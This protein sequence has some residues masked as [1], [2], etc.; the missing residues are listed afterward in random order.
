MQLGLASLFIYTVLSD[1]DMVGMR[2]HHSNA[3]QGCIYTVHR[4]LWMEV[5]V[6]NAKKSLELG[7]S[8]FG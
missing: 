6:W 5:Y 1:G 4:A 7:F 8:L 3:L 2:K